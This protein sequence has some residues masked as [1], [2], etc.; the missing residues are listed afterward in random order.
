MSM[1]DDLLDAIRPVIKHYKPSDE[2]LKKVLDMIP[3]K[4][5]KTTTGGIGTAG[6]CPVC[7]APIFVEAGCDVCRFCAY[8]KCP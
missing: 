1:L 7:G 2:C 5:K 4:L 3:K 8:S 6:P